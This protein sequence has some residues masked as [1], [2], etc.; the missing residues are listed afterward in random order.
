LLCE[1]KLEPKIGLK[2]ENTRFIRFSDNNIDRVV[3]F[4]A[5]L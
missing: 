2:P 1:N 3:D 5:G 4:V